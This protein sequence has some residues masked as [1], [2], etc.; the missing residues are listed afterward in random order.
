MVAIVFSGVKVFDNKYF[1]W[2]IFNK[3]DKMPHYISSIQFDKI[4]NMADFKTKANKNSLS[5]F[6]CMVPH[7]PTLYYDRMGEQ[8][9]GFRDYKTIVVFPLLH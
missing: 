3:S 6:S 5:I 7:L 9:A 4:G 1:Y 8:L 2:R